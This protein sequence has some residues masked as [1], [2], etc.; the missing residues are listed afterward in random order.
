MEQVVDISTDGLHLSK[1]RGFLL[2]SKDGSEAGRVALDQIT[3]LIVHAHGTTYSNNLLIAL[4]E[5][6]SPAVFCAANH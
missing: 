1:D 6:G 4:A 5:H 3:A 2:V